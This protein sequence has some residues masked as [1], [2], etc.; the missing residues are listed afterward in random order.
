VKWDPN[1][2]ARYADERGRP[3]IELVGRI[4]AEQP[5]RVIDLGCGPG[6]LTA[7]LS[8]RWPGAIVEGIDSSPE[9][10]AEASR[11]AMPSLTFRIE[12]I[13]RW[14]VP[15]D[16]GVVVSNAALQW[17]PGHRD[18]VRR[19]AAELVGDAWIG[20][21]VP[22][23]FGAPSH[24]LMRELAGSARWKPQLGHLL[25][26][27]D[28]VAPVD[29]YA[30]LLLEAG[31]AADVWE[32]NYVHV[33]PGEDPVLEWVRGTGLRPILAALSPGEAEE[34]E[35]AYR[36]ELRTAYPRREYGTLF[37]FQRIFAV[38]HRA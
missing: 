13:A 20:F 31:L 37:P 36:E 29:A 10:I 7:L 9:M 32:T 38:G 19:W 3:F 8:A 18:L 2:Y 28:S 30:A 23:N 16:A 15:A 25:R 4:R 1:Q 34:F 21:Q 26:H 35:R 5:S 11:I 14:R 12:D 27:H 6:N 33:L 22:S 24:T 17:V